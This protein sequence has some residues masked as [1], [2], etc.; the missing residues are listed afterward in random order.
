MSAT[1]PFPYDK[2][3]YEEIPCDLCRGTRLAVLNKKDRNGL[4]VTTCICRNCGLIF[5]T[6]RMTKEWYA[7]YYLKEYREQMARFRG[8]PV[9]PL[10]YGYMF[11]SAEKHG[12]ALASLVGPYI[13]RGLTIE[14]GSSAGG[15]LSGF[16]HQLGVEVLGIE[17]SKDEAD[18]AVSRG[19][20][21]HACLVEDF[22]DELPKAANVICS[23][24]LNHLLSP[25]HFLSWAHSAL[26]TGGRLVLEV[27]NFRHVFRRFHYLSRAIQIDHTFMFVPEVLEN[28]VGAAGFDILFLDSDE[29]KT[30][31]E[32]RRQKKSGLPDHHVR[33]VAE[34]SRREPFPEGACAPLYE[35]VCSSL[36]RIRNTYLSYFIRFEMKKALKRA[37]RCRR[38]GWS[39]S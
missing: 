36:S 3:A 16:R 18:Y 19:I 22:R 23:Q 32:L 30:K 12:A 39:R 7:R 27:Q 25:R 33:L 9:A 10:D 31:E 2:A 26:D 24:S 35:K 34:K 14:A 38:R 17:P 4:R 13:S 8:E 15:V 1:T 37:W 6:P 28:F 11:S 29:G 5:I 20:P 21:T